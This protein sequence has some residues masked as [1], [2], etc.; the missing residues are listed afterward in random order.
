MVVLLV[1]RGVH[2]SGSV[3]SSPTD[4]AMV[5]QYDPEMARWRGVSVA[6]AVL[7]L[8]SC[9]SGGESTP[10][11]T[12]V[13]PTV[14]PST[15]VSVTTGSSSTTTMVTTT[16]DPAEALAEEVEADLLEA[17]R[18]ANEA[19]QDPFDDA[20]EAA[21]LAKR[22]GFAFE[23][24]KQKLEDY[25][26]RNLAIRPN[27][28]V[29]ARLVVEQPAVL[30]ADGADVAELVTCEVDP[31]VVVEVGAGPGGSDAIVGPELYSYRSTVY[32]RLIDVTWHVEGGSEIT[33][34]EGVA[35]CPAE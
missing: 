18:L 34:W 29:A 8:A 23:A 13:P 17:F 4:G 22:T 15:E 7:S 10:A 16:S 19:L 32:M 20:K 26:Q 24:L 5:K 12:S 31:W 9:S 3:D 21:A 14:P 28:D 33:S 27:P 30:T 25:R 2:G 6:V 1:D 35:E 11:T